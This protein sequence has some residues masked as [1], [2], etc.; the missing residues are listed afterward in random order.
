MSQKEN[1][2]KAS[3]YLPV[4]PK[5]YIP[6]VKWNDYHPHPSL[7]GLRNL[8]HTGKNGFSKVVK[9]CGKRVLID[10]QAYFSWIDEQS[11]GEKNV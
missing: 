7:A 8:I 4:R 3:D 10:E 5:R 6:A 2:I 1:S 11:E 9:R